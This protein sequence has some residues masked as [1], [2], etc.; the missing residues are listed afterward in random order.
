MRCK[1]DV[2]TI[3]TSA[4]VLFVAA[5]VGSALAQGTPGGGRYPRPLLLRPTPHL[6]PVRTFTTT[7]AEAT[8]TDV[9]IA[10][11]D[12]DGFG[13]IAALWYATYVQD[14]P[15][16][17]R[18]LSLYFSRPNGTFE[19]GPELDLYVYSPLPI[20]SSFRLGTADLAVGDFDGDGDPD[21]AATAFFGDEIWMVENLGNRQ[22]A[23]YQKFPFGVNGIGNFLTP[24]EALAGDIDGDGRDDLVYLADPIQYVQNV[25]VHFWS[26]TSTISAMT[27]RNWE[28]MNPE[29]VQWTRGL[30][31]ADFDRDGQLDVAFTGSTEPPN[32][33][34]PALVIWHSFHPGSGHFE[35][36]L[37]ERDWLAS[38]VAAVA[39][40]PGCAPAL[41]CPNLNG[42]GLD[43][44]RQS[45]DGDLDFD[46][47][48]YLHG[49]A[50]PAADRGLAVEAGDLDGDGDLDLV[51][52]QL[53][54]G[55]NE[56]ELIEI[57]LWDGVEQEWRRVDPSPLDTF[58][59]R[60]L[61]GSGVLRPRNLAVGDLYGSRRP[62]IVGGFAMRP[63]AAG[64]PA[65]L[66]VAVWDNGCVGDVTLDGTTADSDVSLLWNM[67]D[68]CG[69]VPERA[70]GSPL[71]SARAA[72]DLTRDGCVDVEDLLL[73]TA[74]LGCSCFCN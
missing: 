20:L 16:N 13:D 22:F 32:E 53:A 36:T 2:K 71:G 35:V 6:I 66:E 73:L 48:D 43:F 45:C 17:L 19:V 9:A 51:A 27:R 61:T 28:G 74:D 25:I 44:M 4:A 41:V 60:S 72:R 15:S 47:E 33:D 10:D 26:T 54:G 55:P 1:L 18:R 21:L 42:N 57:L 70:D 29:I 8:I 23:K 30:A 59:L 65:R 68:D 12:G 58:G 7:P 67:L 31:L 24:P 64:Q 62:E 56:P 3:P 46:S 38:D 50:A 34:V 14:S 69:E 37:Q 5:L 11:F 63:A 52:K 49:F 40:S 39:T